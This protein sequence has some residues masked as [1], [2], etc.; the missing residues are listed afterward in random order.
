LSRES[1]AYDVAV[2]GGGPAGASAATILARAGWRVVVFE[3]DRFPRF[4]IGESLLATVN[5]AF[6]ELGL[7]E[8]VRAAGFV[9]KW[10]A[11]F[12][13]AD[14]GLS[15]HADFSVAA[16]VP[17]PQ[18]FQVRRDRFDELLLR[19]A[20]RSGA[21]VREGHRVL[22]VEF[23]EL[24]EPGAGGATVVYA[25][26]D[27]ARREARVR[28]VV[29][30]SGRWGLLARKLGLRRDEPRLPNIALFAHYSG[31]E[32]LA[33]RRAGD[34]RIVA[35]P[36]LGWFWFIPLSPELMSVGVVLPR[37]VFDRLARRPHEE[38][39]AAAIAETPA[40][41]ALMRGARREWPV[42]VER[43][44]SYG[45][46]AYAGRRWLLAGDAGSFLDPVFSTGVAI[47]LESGVEAGKTLAAA[48][49]EG[50]LSARRF[51]AFDR[52]QG[53]RYRA[54]RR[55][56]LGFYTPHF[57]DVFFQPAASASLFAAVVA[58]LAGHWRPRLATRLRVELFFMVVALQRWLPLLP[59]VGRE[60]GAPRGVGARPAA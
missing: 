17:V 5:Q 4:H 22:D 12:E 31:V 37:P 60:P 24:A 19:H 15:R 45:A 32:R 42:R 52:R 38:T 2:I 39:L 28:A 49:A 36:D 34:I 14:G 43:D 16:E 6:V 54:F 40:A 35:R 33:G 18:T 10:G 59:R 44:F 51:R 20:A 57:R 50:D 41:A 55:F 47:A 29:D 1:H 8:A 48:L 30:A 58:V 23:E 11:S 13:P 46:R 21:E 53:K 7:V 26:E 3:R 27:G 56:V 9:E 25:G